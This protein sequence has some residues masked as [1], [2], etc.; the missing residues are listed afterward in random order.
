MCTLKI[1]FDVLDIKNFKSNQV[2]A[3]KIDSHLAIN[4]VFT[5]FLSSL[6]MMPSPQDYGEE[7][8]IYDS[9]NVS[10]NEFLSYNARSVFGQVIDDT[11]LNLH[12]VKDYINANLSRSSL[13]ID[14]ICKALGMSR[15]SLYRLFK[16]ESHNI[17]DYVWTQ[18]VN[19]LKSLLESPIH[20]GQTITELSFCVGFSSSSHASVLFKKHFGV[21]PLKYRAM[22]QS[23]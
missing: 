10:L 17:S 3:K 5:H 14:N 11:E 9:F 23:S 4:Y 1:P 22:V 18:R 21:A 20:R 7:K 6:F 15:S 2:T 16:D 19:K 8:K 13:S 12:K